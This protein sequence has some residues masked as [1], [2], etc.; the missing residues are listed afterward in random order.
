MDNKEIKLKR[1]TST[2][3]T[4]ISEGAYNV[5]IGLTILWGLLLNI[6]TAIFLTPYIMQIDYRII[7]IGYLVLSFGCI[8][9]VFKSHTPAISF[10]GFTGL[11]FVMG[12]LL[13]FFLTAYSASSIY[14]AF[15]TTGIIVLSMMILSMFFPAFFLSIGRVL[16]F[17]LI[18]SIV[19]E[20]I[21]GLLL[22]LPLGIMD[23]VVVVIFAGYIGYDWA[24]AQAY[25]KTLDNAIDSAADIYVDIIN[26]FIRIL[27]IIGKKD[28]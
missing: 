8:A 17:A 1:L 26:I 3:G 15:L 9:V 20:L 6:L 5:T 18:G 7:L 25:P 24:K 23:Y 14:S 13:T 27:S 16:I 12:V 10:L 11:A 19:I 21:G 4:P 2:D 22:H 28:N